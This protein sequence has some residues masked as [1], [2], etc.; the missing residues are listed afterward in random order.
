M[1]LIGCLFMWLVVYL[2][3]LLIIHLFSYL[4]D[5]VFMWLVVYS[6]GWLSI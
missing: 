2:V 5:Y 6:C 1:Y 4:I 3:G